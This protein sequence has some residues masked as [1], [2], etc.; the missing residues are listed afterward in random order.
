MQS[1]LGCFRQIQTTLKLPGPH[2]KLTEPCFVFLKQS[3]RHC[4]QH[5]PSSVPLLRFSVVVSDLVLDLRGFPATL[6]G[7]MVKIII[8]SNKIHFHFRR[9]GS[10]NF[11]LT[12]NHLKAR[13]QRQFLL[14]VL[15]IP[16]ALRNLCTDQKPHEARGLDI[17]S[18][19][20]SSSPSPDLFTQRESAAVPARFFI[21][22]FFAL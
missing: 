14:C 7:P 13:E 9:A 21:A 10:E 2:P 22:L 11:N 12:Q 3:A 5:T 6:Q 18:D 4:Y 16:R 19:I 8:G 15:K 1:E 17:R 20:C